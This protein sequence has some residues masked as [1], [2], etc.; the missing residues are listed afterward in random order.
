M[1]LAELDEG[2][3]AYAQGKFWVAQGGL[4]FKDELGIGRYPSDYDADATP[5]EKLNVSLEPSR[6]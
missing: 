3:M 4:S 2:E 1:R 6:S 5:M